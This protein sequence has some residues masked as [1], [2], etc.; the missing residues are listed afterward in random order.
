MS[1][2]YEGGCLCGAVRYRVTGAPVAAYVCHCSYCQRS[3]GTAFQMPVFF[4]AR[5]V[6]FRGAEMQTF[7]Y[8]S[9]THG[10]TIQTQF[11]PTC[12]TRVGSRISRAPGVQ[13]IAAGTMD[14]R[15]HIAVTCH[16]FTESKAPWVRLP[17]EMPCYA[18]HFVSES[19]E[20]QQ[21]I[22]VT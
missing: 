3:S 4:K 7:D 10:R 6:E 13:V 19:G 1:E 8:V 15:H 12:G 2:I 16:L 22:E 11:C 9:P 21:A 14:E 5:Q 18:Q 20:P 17:L